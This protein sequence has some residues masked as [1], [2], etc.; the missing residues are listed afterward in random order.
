MPKQ[1]N[2]AAGDDSF[3][4]AANL[5]IE[6]LEKASGELERT[7]NQCIFQL[8]SFTE[9]LD[10][11][12]SLQLEKVIA[13][14]SH[15]VDTHGG[16]LE[17]KRDETLDAIGRLEGEQLDALL[18]AS[19]DLRKRFAD[20]LKNFWRRIAKSGRLDERARGDVLGSQPPRRV[21]IHARS[22][23]V[24]NHGRFPCDY[25]LSGQTRRCEASED[26]HRE[27][28]TFSLCT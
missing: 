20:R 8:T 17:A 26:V 9:G 11:S 6:A 24:Q 18:T 22:P 14:S 4:S 16:D 15:L 7:V 25:R 28:L 5:M 3:G 12:L 19:E 21:A 27:S 23:R 13:Q 10:K 1:Q 2:P